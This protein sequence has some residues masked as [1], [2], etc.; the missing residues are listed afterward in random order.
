MAILWVVIGK[1]LAEG[2]LDMIYA[3]RKALL[4]LLLLISVAGLYVE[5][6]WVQGFSHE[7][8]YDVYIGLVPVCL[9]AFLFL[10]GCK[11]QFAW[12]WLCRRLSVVTFCLHGSVMGAVTRT[13]TF[14]GVEDAHRVVQFSATVAI[15][16]IAYLIIDKLQKLPRFKWLKVSC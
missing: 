12:A 9:I 5:W 7:F 6:K 1:T 4:K 8:K 15:C 13:R 3:A 10:R 16:V 14:F 2:G 11:R